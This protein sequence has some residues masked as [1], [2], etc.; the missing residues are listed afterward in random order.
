METLGLAP[1]RRD[2]PLSCR[3]SSVC[4]HLRSLSVGGAARPKHCASS[5]PSL[6]VHPALCPPTAHLSLWLAFHLATP[7]AHCVASHLPNQQP[8]DPPGLSPSFFTPNPKEGRVKEASDR[9]P[10][11]A[12]LPSCNSPLD[13]RGD[14]SPPSLGL[15]LPL[16]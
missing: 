4:G 9:P 8:P 12:F 15:P 10:P 2:K 3:R 16:F 6:P 1:T 11:A 14:S 13:R 5:R 7:A